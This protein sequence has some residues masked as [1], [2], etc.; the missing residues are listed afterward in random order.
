A[1]NQNHVEHVDRQAKCAVYDAA[2]EV[3]IRIE[4]ALHEVVILQRNFFQLLGNVEDRVLDTELGQYAV[5]C[6]LDDLRPGV[7]VLVYAVS[8]SHQAEGVVLILCLVNPLLDVAAV[9]S[10]VL[11]H[12]DYLLVGAAVERSPKGVDAGGNG[13][14][15]A[16]P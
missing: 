2:V 11:E 6:P 4:F 13:C 9:L 16:G 5:G 15:Y 8:E 10:Y 1:S 12:H 14:V 7:E 3:D